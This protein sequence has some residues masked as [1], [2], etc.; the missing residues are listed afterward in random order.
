[1]EINVR[2]QHFSKPGGTIAAQIKLEEDLRSCMRCKFFCGNNIQCIVKK[3]VK[4]EDRTRI[5]GPDRK[6]ICFGC[7]YRQSEGYC[8]PCMKKLLEGKGAKKVAWKQEEKKDG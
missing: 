4:E 3:C 2:I 5:V 8:F 7:P 6:S 1:M